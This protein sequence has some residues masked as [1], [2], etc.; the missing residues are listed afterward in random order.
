M[1]KP[2][3]T[4]ASRVSPRRRWTEEEARQAFEAFEESGLSVSAFAKT[5]GI[6]PQ[7]LSRWRR[8]WEACSPTRA[9]RAAVDFVEVRARAP[10]RVEVVLRSGRMLRCAE[11]I[12]DATLRRLVGVLEE[13]AEC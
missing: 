3:A 11:E 5:V 2:L 9:S 10:E 7:R 1:P 13:E 6:N 12:A 4:I 8:T